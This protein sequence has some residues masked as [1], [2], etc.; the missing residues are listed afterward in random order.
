[1]SR[2]RQV[3]VGFALLF[4]LALANDSL[5][6]DFDPAVEELSP[7]DMEGDNFKVSALL[8]GDLFTIPDHHLEDFDGE[9]G[10]WTRRIY[11]TTDFANFGLGDTVIRLR[12]EVN[13]LDDFSTDYKSTLKDAYV[14]FRPGG[15]KVWLGRIPTLTFSSVE[16][17]WGYRWFEKTPLDIQG[18]PSRFDGVRAAGPLTADGPFYY[19]LGAG[20]SKDLGFATD[21]VKKGQVAFTYMPK[22][23]KFFIDVYVDYL[24]ESEDENEDSAWSY[25]LFGG[26]NGESNYAGLHYFQ[27]DWDN[28]PTEKLRVLSAYFVHAIGNWHLDLV[29]RIDYLLD[30]SIKGDGIDYI[31]FDPTARA[32]AAFAGID[33]KLHKNVDIMPNVKYVTYDTNDEGI[34]PDDD[35]YLNLTVSVTVP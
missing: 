21:K 26:W 15:H 2:R 4:S 22:D 19:R 10:W 30:P 28:H 16:A 6:Q 25:Q 18:V 33:I 23:R 20:Q 9:S 5:A 31:P 32:T 8:F 35:L 7:I 1:M 29:G 14:Q 17:H 12:L 34:R 11:L 13:Q 24:D 27:R 3:G